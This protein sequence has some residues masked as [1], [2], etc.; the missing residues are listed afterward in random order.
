ML[1]YEVSQ[2]ITAVKGSLPSASRTL[3]RLHRALDFIA[4]FFKRLSESHESDKVASIA[5]NSYNETLA[6]FHPWLIR[7]GTYLAMYA[8]PSRATL[9][10]KMNDQ[11]KMSESD[12][13]QLLKNI[14]T[15][16][17]PIYNETQ[18]LYSKNDLLLLP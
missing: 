12:V 5:S 8:L 14:S 17:R 16:I 15:I 18:D 7:K 1:E 11:S 3:L 6:N 2:G 10:A 4:L 9:L 13:I